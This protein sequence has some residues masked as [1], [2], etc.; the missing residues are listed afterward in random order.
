M[1][2]M[3][4]TNSLIFKEDHLCSES[5]LSHPD[6]YMYRYDEKCMKDK[7]IVVWELNRD[8]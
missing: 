8:Y 1:R 5:E 4:I 6:K 2:D 7:G 3:K